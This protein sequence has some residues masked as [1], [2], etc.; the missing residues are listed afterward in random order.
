GI[1]YMLPAYYKLVSKPKYKSKRGRRKRE[2]LEIFR[3][4]EMIKVIYAQAEQGITERQIRII[5]T[6]KEGIPIWW[7]K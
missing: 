3:N 4:F 6:D 7:M 2:N 1:P 5:N